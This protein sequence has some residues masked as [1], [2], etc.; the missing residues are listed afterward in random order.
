M[1]STTTD[2]ADINDRGFCERL[3][4]RS[5]DTLL[6]KAGDHWILSSPALFGAEEAF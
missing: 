6:P 4:R 5:F 2:A 1:G 3:T